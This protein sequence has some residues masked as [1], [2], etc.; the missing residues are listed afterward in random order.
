MYSWISTE[1][2]YAGFPLVLR[3]PTNIDVETLRPM[4]PALAVVTHEFTKRKPDG[5]PEPNYNDGLA[6]MDHELIT[7]FDIDRMGVP[8][9]VETFGGKRHY[10]F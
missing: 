8:A 4:F 3:R 1:K 5:L 6:K 7:A 10:Y 9:L 2:T